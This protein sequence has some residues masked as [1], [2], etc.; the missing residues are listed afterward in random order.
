LGPESNVIVFPIRSNLAKPGDSVPELFSDGLAR[1]RVRLKTRDVVAVSS[2]IVGIAE[3]RIR[4]LESVKPGSKA[5]SLA[6]KYSLTAA[7]AQAVLDEA[8]TVIGGVKGAL[9]TVK[10]GDA[11]AN[12]GIDRKNAPEGAVVLWPRNADL[13]AK[14]IRRS[15]RRKS[16]KNVGMVIVDS[17]VSPLRLGTTGFAI[18]CAGFKPVEDI[19]G[20]VDLSGRRIEITVRAIADGIAAAAQLVMGEAADRIPFA[21]VRDAPV[22]FGSGHGIRSAKLAWNQCLYMSQIPRTDE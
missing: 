8:D 14:N 9:L 3:K 20:R 13:S 12:A 2:K 6:R 5:K 18:G 22:T 7:F 19:R 16:G 21:V 11:V 4:Y 1:N 17:R 15:I 10:N